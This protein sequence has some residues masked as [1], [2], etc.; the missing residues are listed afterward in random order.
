MTTVAAPQTPIAL[1]CFW[2]LATLRSGIG[3]ALGW[4]HVDRMWLSLLFLGCLQRA[5]GWM[6]VSG[7]V[8]EQ[9]MFSMLLLL[10]YRHATTSLC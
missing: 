9:G 3:L 5:P 6:G 4:H 8:P 1:V 10:M 2:A 7:I